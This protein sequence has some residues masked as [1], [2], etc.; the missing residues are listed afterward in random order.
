MT[1]QFFIRQSIILYSTQPK[2]RRWFFFWLW[3]LLV[4]MKTKLWIVEVVTWMAVGST[5]HPK[6]ALRK[7]RWYLN[8]LHFIF[9]AQYCN[10]SSF[11]FRQD[12]KNSLWLHSETSLLTYYNVISGAQYVFFVSSLQELNLISTWGSWAVFQVLG[13]KSTFFSHLTW[14][15]PQQLPL[16]RGDHEV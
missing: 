1:R 4:T 16:Y 10:A 11:L 8:P 9:C 15:D 12:Q 2:Y 7:L 13:L 3:L 5:K 6:S 14:W